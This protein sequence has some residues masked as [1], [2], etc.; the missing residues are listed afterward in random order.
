MAKFC[1]KCGTKL[2]ETTGL[3]PKCDAG[4]MNKQTELPKSVEEPKPKQD[5]VSEPKKSLSKKEAKKQ[6]KADKK[7]AKIDKQSQK[8]AA[9]KAKKKEKW[10]SMT[11]GQKI[12]RFSLKLI[13]LIALLIVVTGGMLGALSYWDIIEIPFIDNILQVFENESDILDEET[14]FS[15]LDGKFTETKVTDTESAI[16]AVQEGAEKLGLSNAAQELTLSSVNTVHG[17]T[18]YRLQQNY[19][20]YPVY[21]KDFVLL[22]DTYGDVSGM[23]ANCFDITIEQMNPIIT[24]EEVN[25]AISEFIMNLADVTN[26]EYV[27]IELISKENLCIYTL[28]NWTAKL[29]YEL[30]VD[31]EY[32]NYTFFVDA[33]NAEIVFYSNNTFHI[34]QEFTYDGQQESCTFVAKAGTQQNEMYYIG[35][36][37]TKITIY[38]PNSEHPYDWYYDNNSTVV[39]WS[40]NDVPD[41]SAVDA[42]YNVSNVYNYYLETFNQSSLNGLGEDIDVYIHT[43]GYRDYKGN[44]KSHINNAYFWISPNG[45]IISFTKRYDNTGAEIDE[46][47]CEV[48]VIGHEFT[49]GI[50]AYTAGLSDTKNNLMPGAINEA[51]ADIMGYCAEAV[52]TEKDIDWTSSVRTSI[53]DNNTNSSYIY[54][55]DDY[56]G[57]YKECH[58]A[59]TIVS[60]AAYLMNSADIGSLDDDEVA[61]LWY[62]TIL[63]LPSNCTF[64]VLRQHVELV[65]KNLTFSD[66]QKKCIANAFDAVGITSDDSITDNEYNPDITLKVYDCNSK[67]YDDYTISIEG[68]YN[69]GWFGWSW[70][71]LFEKDYSE[72]FSVN[73]AEEQHI[74]LYPNGEYTI[75]VSDDGES[76]ETYEKKVEVKKKYENS[77]MSFATDY[78]KS[79]IESSKNIFDKSN[80]PDGAV[81]LNGHYYFIYNEDTITDWNAALQY[82]NARNGYLATITSQEENDFLYSYIKQEGYE[83]AYFGLS[84]AASEGTWTWANGEAVTYTNWHKNEPNGENSGED[85]ALFYYKY[86]DGTWNDGDFGNRTVNSGTAFI[87]EWGEYEVGESEKQDEPIRTTSDERDIVLVLD[88]SGSMSGTPME[89][90]KKA[91]VNFIDTILDEDASIG[92]VTYDNSASML[93]DFSV[94]KST[95]TNAVSDIWDGGGTNIEAGLAKAHSML[96]KSNAKKKIIVLMSDGEPN[97]GKEG[98]D[99]IAYADELKDDG[100]I[101]Y[102]LGF[103]E[104]MGSYK[105]SA[106]LLM[107]GIASDGCHYEVASADDLVFFFEDVADQINGQKYIYIRIACPVDVTV[108]Y[109]GETLCSAEDD[110]NVRTDFGTLTFEDNENISGEKQDDRIKVLRLKE[111]ADY[112]VQ[113]VGT[114]HGIMDY[115]IGFMD[116]NGD[117]SDFRR[118]ENIKITRRTT[119][120]TVAAVSKESILNID[121]D[122][123]GKYDLK[124]R[125][126]ENGYG[127]EVEES[128]VVYVVIS[129]V[130]LLLLSILLFAVQ[131]NKKIKKTKEK[132]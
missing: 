2:D 95:L 109:K 98:D 132:N 101:I 59:S 62:H 120:D 121:E 54:H 74:S 40:K 114:G 33:N 102:T 90:T 36:D 53:K 61:R 1:G 115:T 93:S 16:K 49:H 18:Y 87:C 67:A 24:Q 34:Q 43:I 129:G 52:I 35:E 60:Y 108:T 5:M 13:L 25:F 72:Q 125:A 15:I 83:S 69:T 103:F 58:S 14:E 92:I 81:E 45:P 123:D 9:K 30:Y 57:D 28:E 111:G 106:Q 27:D 131:R 119:I 130:A 29:V 79:S 116:E 10:A 105:S 65:A 113:I 32:G 19:K 96:S 21:G 70:F 48:D 76:E 124:L 86:S 50:V 6:R 107:E 63:T 56:K 44:D 4:K 66:Q 104:N 122:G 128:I 23:T 100:I 51:V 85:Y 26:L 80:I 89:E 84:D 17:L 73:S 41:S 110:L 55:T 71:G 117:Y 68:K 46:Y 112:D 118:F 22:V 11:F 91:S 75:T 8:K 39:S 99:L 78:G 7:A 97:D 126:E 38:I 77:V 88:V 64:K 20:G 3:C 37:G 94:N 42:M 12:R 47:S 31:T 82:C 127:E